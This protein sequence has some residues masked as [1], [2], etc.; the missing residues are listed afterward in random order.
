MESAAPANRPAVDDDPTAPPAEATAISAGR[1]AL[2]VQVSEVLL[3]TPDPDEAVGQLARV[4]VPEL[5]DWSFIT[6]LE[7]DGK[8]HDIGL[9]HR[10]PSRADDLQA[11]SDCHLDNMT[12]VA[13]VSVGLRTGRAVVVPHLT[14]EVLATFL[15]DPDV[16]YLT[17][18]LDPRGVA[19]FPL[20]FADRTFGV[21]VSV[22][23][24]AR[25]SHTPD[26]L[27][28]L[29]E[30]S[31]RAGPVL[32]AA[33]AARR[34]RMLAETMQ[35]SLLRVSDPAPS[36]DAAALYRP[37]Y[38]DR[39]VGGDW[40]DVFA[41]ADGS[42]VAT[43]GDVMGHDLS[44]IAAM[45][46]LRSFL[47]ANAWNG[48]PSPAQV[49]TAT[50]AVS[51]GLGPGTFATALTMELSPPG[52]DGSVTVLFSN[53]GHLPPVIVTRTGDTSFLGGDVPPDRPLS[54]SPAAPRAD[55]RC[56]LRPG[57]VVFLYTDGLVERRDRDIDSGLAELA[58]HLAVADLDDLESLPGRMVAAMHVDVT[59]DDDIAVLAI[60]VRDG[61]AA[62][63]ATPPW[64]G[65]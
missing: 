14:D 19:V 1:L 6:V 23:T 59:H 55:R 36:L 52:P 40:Y 13:A 15:P 51:D 57:D 63:A 39:E 21:L 8:L 4:V 50:D 18:R 24:S 43:I 46:Q 47:R 16:A 65:P 53:A 58:G 2:L 32:G 30:V 38:R 31:R 22:T 29:L 64:G 26:E 5:A 48:R 7:E 42:T 62:S 25:G 10:D 60:R 45:A 11:Y 20:Q 27:A 17:R 28:T 37:A 54:V 3:S 35:R 33:R 61:R 56:V 49:L 34:A 12:E 44:A 9:A 41:L